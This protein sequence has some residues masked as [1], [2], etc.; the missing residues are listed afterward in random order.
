MMALAHREQP[1]FGVQFHPESILTDH[2]YQILSNFLTLTEGPPP[3]PISS[4]EHAPTTRKPAPLPT[5]PVTF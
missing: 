2:G 5:R 3:R 4:N 1:V